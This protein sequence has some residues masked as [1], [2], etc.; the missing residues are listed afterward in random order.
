MKRELN[1]SFIEAWYKVKRGHYIKIII[2]SDVIYEF[3]VVSD[4]I[5]TTKNSY[6]M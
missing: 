1:N 6:C 2:N 5:F 3:K 4:A